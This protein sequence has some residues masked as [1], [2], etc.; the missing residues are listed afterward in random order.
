M[1]TT[2]YCTLSSALG[3]N[4]LWIEGCEALQALPQQILPM[5]LPDPTML[6]RYLNDCGK[7]RE[8]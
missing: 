2:S 7:K 4:V 1:L 6:V 8:Y 3:L 5:V